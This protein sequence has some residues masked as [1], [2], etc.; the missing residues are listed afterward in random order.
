MSLG[1][2]GLCKKI[3][4]DDGMV[5]YTYGG[6]NWNDEKSHSGDSHLQDGIFAI[7]KQKLTLSPTPYKTKRKTLYWPPVMEYVSSGAV[8]VDTECK[9]AFIIKDNGCITIDYIAYMLISHI[10]IK[11]KETTIFAESEW[12]IQ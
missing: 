1:Y 4:E 9:N 7:D 11:Y 3:L 10:L 12:F 6:E 5:I 8:S 2:L